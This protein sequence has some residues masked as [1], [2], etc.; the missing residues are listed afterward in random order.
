VCNCHLA[1]PYGAAHEKFW[2]SAK[3]R[4]SAKLILADVELFYEN[5]SHPSYLPPWPRPYSAIVLPF[6]MSAYSLYWI[7][8]RAAL[9]SS[10]ES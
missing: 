6:Y 7:L 9:V 1:G 8:E 3:F 10:P 4:L 5:T 2:W